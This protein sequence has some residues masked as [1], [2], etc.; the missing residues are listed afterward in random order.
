MRQTNTTVQ[1]YDTTAQEYTKKTK[2]LHPKKEASK[3]LSYIPKGGSI[4]DLGCGPG[5]DAGI[6]ESEGY[7]V[8]GLDPSTKLLEI[9]RDAAP[10][11]TFKHGYAEDIPFMNE[12]FDGVWACASLIHIQRKNLPRVLGEVYRIMKPGAIFAP[13]FKQGRGERAIKDERYGGVEKFFAYYPESEMQ[14][15]L[16][17]SGFNILDSFVK[18]IHDSYATNPWMSFLASK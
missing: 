17:N 13:S 2:D 12:E 3:F 9:A 4:L 16:Q 7:Q 14:E 18:G 10:L 5:R 1:S 6:F 11:S 8:T 15:M